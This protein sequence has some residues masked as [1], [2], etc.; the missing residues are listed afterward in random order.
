MFVLRAKA[1]DSY[2]RRGGL[3]IGQILIF[4]Q[5]YSLKKSQYF[6]RYVGTV[7]KKKILFYS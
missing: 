6:Y 7:K 5:I 1:S 2:G 4:P 3:F